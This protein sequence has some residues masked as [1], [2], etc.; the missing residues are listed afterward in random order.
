MQ[1]NN[2]ISWLLNSMATIFL[3]W[4]KRHCSFVKTIFSITRSVSISICL[5]FN[6]I[7]FYFFF[8]AKKQFLK[9]MKNTNSWLCAKTINPIGHFVFFIDYKL[10]HCKMDFTKNHTWDVQSRCK[11]DISLVSNL[12]CVYPF[13]LLDSEN[14][15]R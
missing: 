3:Q 10:L 6:L 5:F 9:L 2:L 7:V 14:D 4:P 12:I 8:Q 13:L 15:F 1:T 11:F